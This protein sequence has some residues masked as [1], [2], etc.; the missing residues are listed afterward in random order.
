MSEVLDFSPE[1]ISKAFF[2]S[3]PSDIG[4]TVFVTLGIPWFFKR[5]SM[6]RFI[7]KKNEGW[8][9]LLVI[10]HEGNEATLLS[11]GS[12]S[13]EV[14]DVVRLL[15][16][17]KC[18][19]IVGIGLAG[20]LKKEIQIGDIIVPT[21]C[22]EVSAA[23]DKQVALFH[24]RDLFEGYESDLKGFCSQNNIS[25]HQGKLC[26][27]DSLTSENAHFFKLAQSSDFLGA[28]METFYLYKE[29]IRAGFKVS[30]FQVVSDNP[31][32][33]KSFLDK[34]PNEDLNIKRKVYSKMPLLIKNI[35]T[36]IAQ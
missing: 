11:V 16:K 34:I 26:T 22:V 6:S 17:F 8:W 3:L 27:V 24:S 35:A 32:L 20:A 12:G 14:I 31:I 33:H 28:D 21:T 25:L 2:G 9:K 18:R 23:S 36:S 13:C 10:Q 29:A 19:N 5:L 1:K 4:R 15:T 30:S 7:I